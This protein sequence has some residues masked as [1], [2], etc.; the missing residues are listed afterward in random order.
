[1][2]NFVSGKNDRDIDYSKAFSGL[3]VFRAS[4]LTD[5]NGRAGERLPGLNKKLREWCFY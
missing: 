1:M 3:V 2:N 5:G 4:L